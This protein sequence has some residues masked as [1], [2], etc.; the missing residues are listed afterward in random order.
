MDDD[1]YNE[2]LEFYVEICN[3]QGG[4]LAGDDTQTKITIQDVDEPGTIC[5]DSRK[6]SVRKM[7]KF[8]YIQLVRK[9]GAAGDIS[10]RCQTNVVQ[11]VNNQAA[12]YRDF[13][14]IEERVTF[15]H[16]ETEKLV[17]VQLLDNEDKKAEEKGTSKGADEEEQEVSKEN[18]EITSLVFQVKLDRPMPNG[19]QINKQ[20]ICFVEIVPDDTEFN[21][22]QE[23][24]YKMLNYLI[25]SRNMSW[26]KQ[27]KVA[28]ILGPSLDAEGDDVDDVDGSEAC[29]HFISM[30]WKLLFACV[31]PPK[32]C[33]GW[34]AFFGSLCFIALITLV[35]QEFANLL[36][37]VLG[38]PNSVTAITLVA[39]GTSLPDTFASVTAARGSKYADSAVG[40]I[41]GSN[42]VNVFLGLGLPWVLACWWRLESRGTHYAVPSGS[43]KYSVMLFLCTSIVCFIVLILRR[44]VSNFPL[45]ILILLFSLS[46]ENS[47]ARKSP[48]SSAP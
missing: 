10:C 43:L 4:R 2:D 29:I 7:D 45:L 27:F 15:K 19:V 23:A 25:E 44:I 47:E 28:L 46:V 1:E 3:E 14:P 39:L 37:C 20:N 42:S 36:G 31:P 16:Q 21:K 6:V 9:N 24:E 30:G 34:A 38:I 26:S 5:F 11:E 8:V 32:M 12:E 18:E 48:K 33:G 13:L 35:V 41:T 17:K 22:E 40:N